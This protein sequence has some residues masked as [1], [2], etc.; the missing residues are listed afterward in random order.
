MKAKLIAVALANAA[1][2]QSKH[3]LSLADRL[4]DWLNYGSIALGGVYKG[5]ICVMSNGAQ[6]PS[7]NMCWQAYGTPL[8]G[9]PGVCCISNSITKQSFDEGCAN[10]GGKTGILKDC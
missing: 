1:W 10:N 7:D 5:Y 4:A 9:S 8:P 6:N 3:W 2:V